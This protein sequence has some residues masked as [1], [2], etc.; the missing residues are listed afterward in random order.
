MSRDWQANSDQLGYNVLVTFNNSINRLLT[1][2]HNRA[3]PV[4]L[5]N[6]MNWYLLNKVLCL[7]RLLG[8][9]YR[10]RPQVARI[11]FSLQMIA[12]NVVA[13][14]QKVP[15]SNSYALY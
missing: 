14:T 10:R 4:F 7:E 12:E 11:Y 8:L 3:D 1:L 15:Y 5:P 6:E 9:N 2:V 13:S